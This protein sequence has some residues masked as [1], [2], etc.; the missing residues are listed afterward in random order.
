MFPVV[1]SRT[2]Y[3]GYRTA[4]AGKKRV[5]NLTRSYSAGSQRFGAAYWTGDI[6]NDFV[7]YTKQIPAGLNVCM[8]G[9]PLFCTDI[10]GFNGA[11][12]SD[13]VLR[14]FQWGIFNPVFRIHGTRNTELWLDPQ[15]SVEAGLVKYSKLRYRLFPYVYSLAWKVTNE[16]YTMMRGLPFDFRGDANIRD[17][18]NEFMFGPALL[19]C[20]VTSSASAITRPVYLPAGGWYD[21][22]TGKSVVGGA[23]IPNA[24]APLDKIPLYVR[25]G[26][27]LPMGPEISYADTAA[28]PIE[29][30]VYT[31]ANGNFTIYEDEGDSYNYETGAYATIPIS[32]DQTSGNLTIGPTSGSFPGMLTSRIFNVVWVSD[33]HGIGGTVTTVIDKPINYTG[34][35]II[36]NKATGQMGV[37]HNGISTAFKAAPVTR[38]IGRKI[39]VTVPGITASKVMV[40][41]PRGRVIAATVV[42]GGTSSLVTEKLSAGVYFVQFVGNGGLK[43][44]GRI[45][46]P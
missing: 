24:D 32:W 5:C 45:S 9:L 14:W 4:T 17:L 29:L 27:I 41:D 30:R 6:P 3:E 31:G 26:S 46:V 35:V 28:D 19:V 40:V 42:A 1:H 33:N 2:L 18:N 44:T 13:V 15:R 21:F 39:Y 38:L 37:A 25:A 8:T 43:T 36:L 12:T 7:T 10:G 22:W 16:G 11:V 34:D 20:P 23:I